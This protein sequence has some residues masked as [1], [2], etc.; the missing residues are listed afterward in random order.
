MSEDPTKVRNDPMVPDYWL[1]GE[2]LQDKIR[3]AGY[4]AE[5]VDGIA[6]DYHDLLQAASR[7]ETEIVPAILATEPTDS[8]KLSQLLEELRFEFNHVRWHGEAAEG[9]LQ[10]AIA[11]ISPAAKA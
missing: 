7:I 1:V 4:D 9:Y 10:R 8:E 6:V 2:D 11:N 5:T 3:A